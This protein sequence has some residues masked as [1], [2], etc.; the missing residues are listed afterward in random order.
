[1]ALGEHAK[2]PASGR[3]HKERADS[4]IKN[5]RKDY[6]VLKDVNGNKKLGT[7]EKELG[8]SSLSQALKTLRKNKK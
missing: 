6:P 2:N 3:I 1:M 7:L 4:L 8:V 5:L